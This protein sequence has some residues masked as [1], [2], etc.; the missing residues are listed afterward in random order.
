MPSTHPI[1]S[2]IRSSRDG[3]TGSKE[4][5]HSK[6]PAPLAPAPRLPSIHLSRRV[7]YVLHHTWFVH[8]SVYSEPRVCRITRDVLV[9]QR[10]GS[11]LDVVH[12]GVVL[13]YHPLG[14]K[15]ILGH[16]DGGLHHVDPLGLVTVR[17]NHLLS[18]HLD[19][20]GMVLLVSLLLLTVHIVT[21]LPSVDA[22]FAPLRPPAVGD[23]Q[24]QHTVHRSLHA[25]RARRLFGSLRVVEPH[26]AAARDQRT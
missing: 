3:R 6:P 5:M 18:Q 12:L 16:I 11:G 8:A 25:R 14:R 21:H 15:L 7:C 9:S 17:G 24:V 26:V 10:I 2:S 4:P 20:C 19:E 23:A 1:H 22:V 13:V